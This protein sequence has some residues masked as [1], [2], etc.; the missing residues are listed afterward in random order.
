MKQ[1]KVEGN[2]NLDALHVWFCMDET[3]RA[4]ALIQIAIYSKLI[5][6]KWLGKWCINRVATKHMTVS[7]NHD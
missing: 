6:A 2:L 3:W 1:P 4:K 7:I 5:N